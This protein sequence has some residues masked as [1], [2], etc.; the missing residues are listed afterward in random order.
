MDLENL[1]EQITN[2]VIKRLENKNDLTP[3]I[4]SVIPNF[5]PDLF[6][7]GCGLCVQN[8]PDRAEGIIQAGAERIASN[9]G[10]INPRSDLASMI[11]H[12][13]LKADATTEQIAKLCYEA[14]KFNFASVC[15]NPTNVRLSAQLL[16]GSSVKV[17]TVI[18]FPLGATTPEVKA[19][20]ASNAIQDGAQ[21][22]D[23]VINIGALKSS[24]YQL[25]EDDIRSV[26]NVCHNELVL[27]KVILETALLTDEEKIKA[28]VLS[29][30]AGADFVKTSTGFG[31]GGATIED[32]ALMKEVVGS[33]V[34]VK[35]SGGI[36]DQTKAKAMIE[37]G[38]NRIGASAS[39]KIVRG[40]ENK[41]TGY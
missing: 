30:A 31:P 3:I 6:C 25:V 21:E 8:C 7:I 18:G 26:V 38:A 22:I 12:T 13:L 5:Q 19:Y 23:M 33:F 17:C 16:K 40:E 29:K 4:S 28:C 10:L 32:V 24:D 34:G 41:G 36:R 14:M 20:E 11:D 37:A 1:I 35:A 9:I 27:C 2:E 39:I 15:V